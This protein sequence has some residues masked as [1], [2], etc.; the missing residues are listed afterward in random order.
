MSSDELLRI[1]ERA[2]EL[3][4]TPEQTQVTVI[5]ERSLLAHFSDSKGMQVESFGA[6]TVEA[7]CVDSGHTATATTDSPD[8]KSLTSVVAAAANA[9]QALAASGDGSYPGLPASLQPPRSHN[10][11]DAATARVDQ[12]SAAV[13][14]QVALESVGDRQLRANGLWSTGEVTTAIVSGAGIKVTDA[15]TD[16]YLEVLASDGRGLCGYASAAA[17]AIGEISSAAIAEEATS[18][19]PRGE[20]TTLAPGEYTVVFDACAVGVLLDCLG[21]M[22][23]GGLAFAQGTSALCGRLGTRVAASAINLSD[24]PR[25]GSTLP[26]AFDAEG[27]AKAPIPLIQDGVAHRVVHDTRSAGILGGSA[28]ST[29]HALAAGGARTGPAPTNL[30]LVGGGAASIEELTQPIKHGIYVTRLASIKAVSPEQALVTFTTRDGSFLIEDGEITQP[31]REIEFTD[32]LL[33]ILSGVQALGSQP[34]LTREPRF[35]R[36]RFASGVVCPAIRVGGL[37]VTGLAQ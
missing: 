19:I 4:T 2:L 8:A 27:V 10:G 1:A 20:Q 5:K 24:T 12:G 31:I 18:R 9:A 14:G 37:H 36:P 34:R 7:M 6:I 3:A 11:W 22:A 26:R 16:A 30:V 29:G 32:S 33:S 21:R 28:R 17:S 25:F 13:T 15:V 23:F 35:T